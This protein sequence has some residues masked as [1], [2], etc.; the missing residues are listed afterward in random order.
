MQ[1]FM[2]RAVD[3]QHFVVL[4]AKVAYWRINQSVAGIIA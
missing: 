4:A 1:V 2:R 3:V